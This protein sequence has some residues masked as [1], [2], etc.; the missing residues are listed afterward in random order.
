MW[1]SKLEKE[2][3]LVAFFQQEKLHFYAAGFPLLSGLKKRED[4]Q[5]NTVISFFDF[6][7]QLFGSR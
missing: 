1:F 7:F 2:L 6:A 3:P 4:V 5:I